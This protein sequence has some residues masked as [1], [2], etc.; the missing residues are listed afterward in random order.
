MLRRRPR[1][2]WRANRPGV[3]MAMRPRT[4]LSPA[5]VRGPTHRGAHSR[6]A[7]TGR[8]GY[9]GAAHQFGSF[10]GSRPGP[11]LRG[12]RARAEPDEHHSMTA[13]GGALLTDQNRPG[14]FDPDS[15]R[16][17]E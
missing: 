15:D 4:S 14:A 9:I 13:G 8:G 10:A 5:A 16:D 11:P 2:S 3:A 6:A 1:D 12:I 17:D 7:A